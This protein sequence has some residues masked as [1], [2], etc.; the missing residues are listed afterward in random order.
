MSEIKDFFV[1]F[2]SKT[3]SKQNVLFLL[4]YIIRTHACEEENYVK[5]MNKYTDIFS[6]SYW[7]WIYPNHFLF[8]WY[9][10]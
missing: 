6:L 5:I 7:M 8:I 1:Y 4:K 3:K 10:C 9:F 2:M